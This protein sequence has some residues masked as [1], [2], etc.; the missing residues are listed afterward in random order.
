MIYDGSDTQ[1]GPG[2]QLGPAI[3]WRVFMLRSTLRLTSVAAAVLAILAAGVFGVDRARAQ[4]RQKAPAAAPEVE[5]DY[6]VFDTPQA[7]LL[8]DKR[9]GKLWRIG[10]TEVAG[11]RYWFSTYVPREPPSSFADFQQRVRKAIRGAPRE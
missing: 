9:S 3:S 10:Y 7:T 1:S 6:M 8:L 11:Q 2:C 4:I 5:G